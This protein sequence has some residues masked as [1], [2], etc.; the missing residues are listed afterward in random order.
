M[1]VEES[2][3]LVLAALKRNKEPQTAMNRHSKKEGV[4]QNTISQKSKRTNLMNRK[5]SIPATATDALKININ[6]LGGIR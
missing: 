1:T 4:S 3:E 6:K 2:D 5:M